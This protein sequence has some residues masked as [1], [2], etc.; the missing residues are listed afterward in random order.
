MV[1][2]TMMPPTT[3]TSTST[4]SA[5][6]FAAYAVAVSVAGLALTLDLAS[7][8]RVA[9]NPWSDWALDWRYWLFAGLILIGELLPI[10]VP[11]RHGHDRV[12]ISGAFAFAVLL[13]FGVVPALLAY[14]GASIIADVVGRI[15]ALKVAFNAAQ[16]AIAVAGAGAV[17]E[18]LGHQLPADSMSAV[19]LPALAAAGA[20]F[21]INHVLAGIAA[22][23]LVG[24]R[25]ARYLL[26]DLPFQVLTAGFVLALAPVVVAS[27]ESSV[28]LVPLCL[29]PTLAI[30][31]GARQAI[32]DAHRAT[33]DALTDLPNRLMLRERLDRA[34]ARAE[35]ANGEVTLMIL[36][37]DNFKA[38]NDTMGHAYGDRLLQDVTHRL[39]EALGP[40]D[41]L[42]RLGGDEF[43]VLPAHT[44][45]E[46]D[47]RRVARDLVE[48]M[49][50]SFELDGIVL[51]V[52][53]SVGVARF[54]EHASTADNLL[55]K[56]D[57]AL[58]C[59][60]A[61]QEHVEFYAPNQDHYTV[62]RLLLAG[63]LRRGLE[64]GEIVLE[65]QPKFTLVGGRPTG[66]EALAR[67]EHPELGRIGPDGFIP[68]AE[69]SGLVNRLTDVVMAVA[70]AQV[71]QWRDEGLDLRVSVNVSPRTLLDP[72]L[73]RRIR[74]LLETHGVPP[75]QLQLEI[76]ESRPVPSGRAA[77]LVID[78]L[79]T[80]GVSLAIDDFGTG[81]SSL[82]QL[83]RLPVDEIKIDRSFVANMENSASDA[84]IVQ[85]TIDL[86]RNLG[87]AVTAEGVETTQ[88]GRQLAEMGCGMAQGYGL[89]RPVSAERCAQVVRDTPMSAL[90]PPRLRFV[91]GNA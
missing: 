69:Q 28:V 17:M 63:Q 42:A 72:A 76:T 75:R 30:Y 6:A 7:G 91:S 68:L 74:E 67:W 35:S 41:L 27:F 64:A 29:L 33:H 46:E 89:C 52:R 62:D 50:D 25:P 55:R 44:A 1:T 24:E 13:L 85:S 43:A 61:S 5:R 54:P 23:L 60:K 22:A 38:V 73:P 12:T 16:Y 18:L 14:A 3:S 36:D 11:R 48:A 47:G 58:Y 10:D 15:G 49:Q 26:A 90:Q 19:L 78:E 2:S 81:F 82:V 8:E 21:V 70:V 86:A 31:A 40:D 56:A 39:S 51:D 57:V 53:A 79:R 71:A 4:P 34:L 45:G 32:R 9:L 88:L 37:L 65:Y 66:V 20:F 59:A 80:M 84:A 87:L 83:Q 77:Q